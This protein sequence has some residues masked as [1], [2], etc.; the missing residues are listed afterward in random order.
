MV[1]L[2]DE[3]LRRP[4]DVWACLA[5]GA[6]ATLLWLLVR[7][8]SVRFLGF[9]PDGAPNVL[10]AFPLVTSIAAWQDRKRYAQPVGRW[11]SRALG[12]SILGIAIGAPSGVFGLSWASAVFST[13][14]FAVAAYG[15]LPLTRCPKKPL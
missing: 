3:D 4:D 5:A 6:V 13:L 9:D 1:I 8:V 2:N 11:I 7:W 14:G 10:V 12:F 15:A